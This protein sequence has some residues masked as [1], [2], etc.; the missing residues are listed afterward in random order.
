M[1]VDSVANNS[2]DMRQNKLMA[3]NNKNL[4]AQVT[5][6][7]G[8]LAVPGQ[9][10]NDIS[11]VTEESTQTI[12]NS[13]LEQV[14]RDAEFMAEDVVLN[15]VEESPKKAP[16]RYCKTL[17]RTVKELSDRH[18]LVF[19]GMVNR[20]KLDENNAFQTFVIVADE[21]FEDGHVNWGRIVAVY[22]FA[23]RVAKYYSDTVSKCEIDK[24]SDPMV[25]TKSQQKKIALFVG[26]Y[27]AN[28]LGKWI[29][30]H[31]GWDAFVEYFPDQGEFEEK[32]WKGV[33]FTAIGL[34]AL[35]TVVASR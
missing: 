14:R 34:G 21:I 16:N 8:V 2:F 3:G 23:A 19:K 6:R 10:L 32:M 28:K 29:L 1:S 20:L 9:G 5:Q 25:K 22:T 13:P 18:D 4:F 30:D 11:Q 33:L 7:F 31:G 15:F 27:V 17:R 35:A 24:V 12:S 26:K